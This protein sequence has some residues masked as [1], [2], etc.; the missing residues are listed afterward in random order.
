[1]REPGRWSLSPDYD[2]NPVPE[3]DR[4]RMCK[5]AITEDQEEPTIASALAPGLR[6]CGVWPPFLFVGKDP[7]FSVVTNPRSTMENFSPSVLTMTVRPPW[8][9]TMKSGCGTGTN[10][11]SVRRS[12]NVLNGCA[13][14]V[15]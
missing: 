9:N 11:P 2:L 6:Y 7:N 3:M 1:M 4:V 10:V 5:T 13:C 14:N 12:E 8:L 15:L